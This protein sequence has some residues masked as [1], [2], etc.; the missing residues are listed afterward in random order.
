M[1]FNI[2]PT[3]TKR[4]QLVFFFISIWSVSRMTT[5][6]MRDR[7]LALDFGSYVLNY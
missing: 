4:K 2:F 6:L 7:E 3:Y 5:V 1:L